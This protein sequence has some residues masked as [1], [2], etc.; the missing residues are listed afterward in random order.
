VYTKGSGWAYSVHS[1]KATGTL[2]YNDIDG[3]VTLTLNQLRVVFAGTVSVG[4]IGGATFFTWTYGSNAQPTRITN[5]AG[6]YVDLTWTNNRVT[7][8]RDP[9]GGVWTYGYNASGMLTSVT[10]PGP[11]PDV[12]TYHYEDASNGTRLTGVSIN[13]ARYS[14]YKYLSD[15][16]VQE[17]GLV[18]GEQKDTFTYGTNQTTVTNA[19]GQAVTYNF[20]AV[21]GALKLASTSR[22]ATPNCPA[23]VASTAYD[24][25]GW[26]D[27]TLDWNGGKTDY[28]YDVAGKLMSVTTAANT[29]AA[30][31]K[32]N[33]WNGDDLAST[34]YRTAGGT[35]YAKVTYTYVT[36]GLALGKL[37][38][39]T[40]TDLRVGGTRQTTYAYSY[41]PN[42]VLATI[43][44]TQALPGGVSNVTT[45]Q[46]D[47]WGNL[48][49]IANG[50]GHIVRWGNY[51]GLG[52]PGRYVD[53]NG[54][55]TD[56]AYDAKGNKTSETL[57]HP[58][59]TRVANFAYNNNRQVIDIA[60][61]TGR[62]DRLR[63]N[64]AT[65]LLQQGNALNEFVTFSYDISAN[66]WRMR[67]NRHV[68]GWSGSAPTAS[69]AGEF[70]A[71]TEMDSL[72]R[73]RRQVGNNGQVATFTYDN[74]GNVETRTDAAGHVTEYS[75][76]AQNRLTQSI[77]PDGGI[78]AFGYDAEGNLWKVTDP[79]GLVTAY[80]YNG[81]GQVLTRSS[82]DTGTTTYTYDSA[83]RMATET[84]ANGTAISYAWDAL[85]RL[86]SR[87]SGGV[88]E[89]F[90]YDE[91][92]YGKGRLTRIN[93][94][95]GQT[96]YQYG[97]AGELIAQV[98]TIY[99]INYTTSWSYDA[100]GRLY[101]MTYPN[102]M[103]VRHSY[104]AYGRLAGQS[105]YVGGQW[106]TVA[107]AFRYQPAT[108]RLYAWRYG[109]GTGRLA[110]LDTDGRVMQLQSPGVHSLSYGYTTTNTIASITD[111]IYPALSAS[112]TYDPNDRLASVSRSGDAQT[113]TW[114]DVGNRTAQTRAGASYS[115]AYASQANRLSSISGSAAR[116]FE[117]DAAGNTTSDSGSYGNRSFQYDTFNRL[118]KFYLGTSYTG[119]YRNNALNQRAYKGAA[120][121]GTRFVY[122]PGG[123]L[124][125]EAGTQ[126]TAYIW[127]GG[128]LLSVV[129]ANNVYASH[130]D[131]LGR[132]E[133]LT[134]GA[135]QTSWRANN[136]AF[137]RSVAVDTIGGLNVGFPGQYIDAESGLW[138]NWNRYYDA[139]IGRYVQSDPIGLAGGL[140]TYAYARS[141]PIGYVDPDGLIC[142]SQNVRNGVSGAVGAGVSTFV[143]TG[144]VGLAGAMAV[145]GGV[146]GYQTG[147]TGSGVVTGAIS[148]A[149]TGPRGF[150]PASA[151]VG[152]VLGGLAGYE[153]TA[154]GGLAGGALEGTVNANRGARVTNP[155]GFY[156][157]GFGQMAKGFL[158]GGL[159][160][161]ASE[162]TG[163]LIDAINESSGDCTCGK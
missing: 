8:V 57:Y 34:S 3:S 104:D 96:T 94:A 37:A 74:N 58:G 75:Y 88:T 107:N 39:E 18:G 30:L 2:V 158:S 71:T 114:H 6:Q 70:L 61:P 63:Y 113:F 95:T 92:T 54:V 78:T 77:A 16:R 14:T 152:G 43:V 86:T 15:G 133:V 148:A 69:P 49:S 32:V 105:A 38:G 100:A 140:N 150:S 84:R 136:A 44:A 45:T 21:Q 25:N 9:A 112:F 98:N 13:G 42:N 103:I 108:D 29:A 144:N 51:N 121:V 82:P 99:G 89:W 5:I 119:D 163:K 111:G 17:S 122:G 85:S 87:S 35:A 151:I 53:A 27:H 40:W 20:A 33:T 135:G 67:S 118:S 50:D 46:Y 91:G 154:L 56:F 36:A 125:F 97:A 79:R 128:T 115:Y 81:L 126:Q 55:I 48:T 141:N 110:T 11:A 10:S 123:E 149:F 102:G 129:R 26:V 4:S 137:D 139:S 120:G 162:Y 106:R 145:V 143:A 73:V 76:D 7:T 127:L 131:H 72:G 142:I 22:N 132:P 24:A 52:L 28:A 12:R 101:D 153:G 62:V 161:L 134:D 124:L 60:Y 130:N 93:D 80:T 117:Y 147:E 19:V 31:T 23:A 68:P 160:G 159:G 59:G 47:T 41:H 90:T 157:S 156:G 109:N 138:Y 66:T 1:A 83:G 65:R 116:S 155:N 64:A 146:A